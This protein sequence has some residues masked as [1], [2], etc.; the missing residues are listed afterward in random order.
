MTGAGKTLTALED[1]L[2]ERNEAPSGEYRKCPMCAEMIKTE[3]LKCRYCG[4]AIAPR[5][6][7]AEILTGLKLW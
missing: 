7:F 1:W 4:S 3:A 2:A 5:K 6:T